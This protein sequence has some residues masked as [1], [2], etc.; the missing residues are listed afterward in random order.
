M[1]NQPDKA[2]R[3]FER[4]EQRAEMMRDLIRERIEIKPK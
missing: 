3:A 4:Y 2:A 1:I